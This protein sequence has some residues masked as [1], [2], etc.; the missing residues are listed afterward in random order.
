MICLVRLVEALV[1][2]LETML[3]LSQGTSPSLYSS[4]PTSRPSCLFQH[5][6]RNGS[7]SHL[8]HCPR[9]GSDRILEHVASDGHRHPAGSR[10]FCSR[11]ADGQRQYIV[12]HNYIMLI[13]H[14]FVVS[15]AHVDYG[16]TYRRSDFDSSNSLGYRRFNGSMALVQPTTPQT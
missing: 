5:S 12:G 10:L 15:Y 13:I 7:L 2:S 8:C 14:A 9:R 11:F 3:K 16:P 1:P 4:T 6:A